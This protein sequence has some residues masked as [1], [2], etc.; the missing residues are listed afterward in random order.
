MRRISNLSSN[1]SDPPGDAF[2]DRSKTVGKISSTKRP[3]QR[4]HQDVAT[5][6]AHVRL[7]QDPI[8]HQQ[9]TNDSPSD[10]QSDD[11]THKRTKVLRFSNEV[12]NRNSSHGSETAR[13]VVGLRRNRVYSQTRQSCQSGDSIGIGGLGD[14]SAYILSNRAHS[15]RL[16]DS[17]LWQGNRVIDTTSPFLLPKQSELVNSL[18][19]P[20]VS[21]PQ[22]SRLMPSYPLHCVPLRNLASRPS[23]PLWNG[24]FNGSYISRMPVQQNRF[25]MNFW[26]LGY[27]S[28]LPT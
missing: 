24:F 25:L 3:Q 6:V 7:V 26:S 12:V 15:S 9:N 18:L 4:C 22:V 20:R 11:G 16:Y 14:Q 1:S 23:A 8:H 19:S 27:G 10:S 21:T 13:P 2:I 5:T 17:P 28:N